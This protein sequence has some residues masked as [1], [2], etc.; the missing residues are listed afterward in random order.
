MTVA[1]TVPTATKYMTRSDFDDNIS[2]EYYDI[3]GNSFIIRTAKRRLQLDDIKNNSNIPNK[4]YI[5]NERK[6][7]LHS[8]CFNC[9]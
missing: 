4:N 3:D 2:S 5:D 8:F 7:D 9:R 6:K 1:T